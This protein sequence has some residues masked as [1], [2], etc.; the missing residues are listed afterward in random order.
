MKNKLNKGF[1]LVELLVVIAIIGILIAL[2]LP[3]V[4]AAREAARRMQCT[5]NL[6]QLALGMHNYHDVV[7]TLPPVGFASNRIGWVVQLLPYI[8]QQNLYS[9]IAGGGT[10]TSVDGTT[11]YGPFGGQPWDQNYK[12]WLEKFNLRYCP[13]DTA[14]D[15]PQPQ[16]YPGCQNYRIC[17]GDVIFAYESLSDSSP[18]T[19]KGKNTRG[20]GRLDLG[21]NFSEDLDGTS[22]TIMFSEAIS[23]KP[24][25]GL[26]NR[27]NTIFV[28]W[29][30]GSI[31]S[32]VNG[33]AAP[34]GYA[35]E[36]GRR[37]CESQPAHVGFFST[38]PPNG[39]N[40]QYGSG[41]SAGYQENWH[42]I[43]TASSYHSGG[44]NCCLVDGSV[45]FVSNTIDCGDTNAETQYSPYMT[46]SPS[47]T[48]ESKFGVWGA[49][50]SISGGETKTL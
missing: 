32:C 12:P 25:T 50:G 47:L 4:Q 10:T 35:E 20:I 46:T 33:A 23:G 5:N 16:Y 22:N 38:V 21:R 36:Y 24:G 14:I 8:E 15:E 41:S 45:R 7:S 27:G 48:D 3:A 19:S 2:L 39:P 18:V 17:L 49:Y 30:V 29:S 9:W 31:A 37:W 6:K 34:E 28:A 26:S 43:I 1:T 42:Q 13:S 44:V 40:C 11:N